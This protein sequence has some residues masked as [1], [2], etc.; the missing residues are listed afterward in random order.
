M[1]TSQKQRKNIEKVITGKSKNRR[2][3]NRRKGA[4]LH[5]LK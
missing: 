2:V 5:L 4:L 3:K 1:K